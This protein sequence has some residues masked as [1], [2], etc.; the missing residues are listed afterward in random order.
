MVAS[1]G[2]V[3]KRLAESRDAAVDAALAA[4][5][6]AE[7][8]LYLPGLANATV[9]SV[10][11]ARRAVPADSMPVAGFD[12]KLPW[13]Y[14]LVSHSGVTLSALLSRLVA[15]EIVEGRVDPRLEAYRPARFAA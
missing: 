11:V 10:R 8:A 6:V 4:A 3:D 13:L 1:T 12:P 9:T 7:A 14:H 2:S 5:A 15:D